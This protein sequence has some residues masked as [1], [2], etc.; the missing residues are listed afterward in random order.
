MADNTFY[1]D[2]CRIAP[3]T[4]RMIVYRIEYR[5]VYST[6][7]IMVLIYVKGTQQHVT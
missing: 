3:T 5:I 4:V 7:I 6:S 2:L 1:L